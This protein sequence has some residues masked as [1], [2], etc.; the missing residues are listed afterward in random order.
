MSAVQPIPAG[1]PRVTPYLYVDGGAAAID[2][3]VRVLGATES[4]RMAG[5][6][7][8]SGTPS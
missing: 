8:R 4:V 2:F 1:Y 5:P 7:G 3:Y 6:E